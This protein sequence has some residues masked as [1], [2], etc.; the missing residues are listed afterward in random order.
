MRKHTA[1]EIAG[2]LSRQAF[3]PRAS[4]TGTAIARKREPVQ[5][6]SPLPIYLPDPMWLLGIERSSHAVMQIIIVSQITV[7]NS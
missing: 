3:T 5:M 1:E 7:I 4:W 6:G 2:V